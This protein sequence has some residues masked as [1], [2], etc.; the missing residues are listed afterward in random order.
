MA[1]ART[2]VNASC[3]S[4]AFD[5]HS[6]LEANH[7]QVFAC[8]AQFPQ[9]DVAHDARLSMQDGGEGSHAAQRPKVNLPHAST[10]ISPQHFPDTSSYIQYERP[11]LPLLPGSRADTNPHPRTGTALH[12]PV[13]QD[14]G[15]HSASRPK[16]RHEEAQHLQR[17]PGQEHKI[18]DASFQDYRPNRNIAPQRY[19]QKQAEAV[20]H[21]ISDMSGPYRIDKAQ[22]RRRV[23]QQVMALASFHNPETGAQTEF[24]KALATLGAAHHADQSRKDNHI[25]TQAEHFREVKTLLQDQMKQYCV[26]IS[27]WKDKHAAL[28]TN[29]VHLREK[30]KTN[31][32][33]VSG[34]QKDHEK[35]QRCLVAL[36]DECK[37]VLEE[38]VA[39]VEHEKKSLLLEF[40]NTLDI[41]GK[42]QKKLKGTVDD[43][44]VRLRISESK[45][46]DLTENMT[47][48]IAMYEEEK[49][50]RNDLES[51][52]FPSIRNVQRQLEDRST[53]IT[54]SIST[55]QNSINKAASGLGQDT[56]LQECIET[57]RKFQKTPFLTVKDGQ[58]SEGML[59]FMYDEYVY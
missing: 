48:Q 7:K 2:V 44:Y 50:R 37:K 57:L 34:L 22:K 41:L 42:G 21:G 13:E 49:A 25:T 6:N 15:S 5:A 31:Q 1:S 30:A 39:E 16:T 58:K 8:I 52:L 33:Y 47:K 23:P 46:R 9:K 19:H 54:G 36:Q 53:Q 24:D 18:A 59:R 12:L 43:L 10:D 17:P 35:L 56:S 20:L 40:N 3:A 32:K 11:G 28:S 38:K 4:L 26:T 14:H 45:R 51:Q 29:V 55:L 27:E